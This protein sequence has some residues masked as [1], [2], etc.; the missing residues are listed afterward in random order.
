MTRLKLICMFALIC[1]FTIQ[2]NKDDDGDGI[3]FSPNMSCIVNSEDFNTSLIEILAGNNIVTITATDGL[4]EIS[5][6]LETP[7]S[8]GLTVPLDG[9]TISSAN[10]SDNV[11]N[12]QYI[13]DSGSLTVT[14][15][16]ATTGEMEGNFQFHGI[17]FLGTAQCN[18]IN[19]IFAA[20]VPQ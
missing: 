18:V 15:Y 4:R 9:S 20:Q 5:L 2:C 11:S 13:S 1:A 19:G 7:V 16:D 3:Q 14:R 6:L 12:V 10:F 17:E 8:E